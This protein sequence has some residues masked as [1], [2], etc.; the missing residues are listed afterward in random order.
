MHMPLPVPSSQL[1][2]RRLPASL[3]PPPSQLSQH[4]P[5][6]LPPFSCLPACLQA[7]QADP[8]FKTFREKLQAS[9]AQRA[10]LTLWLGSWR[11][12][13]SLPSCT[14]CRSTRHQ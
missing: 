3:L 4:P 9:T 13:N 8:K 2:C 10:Q 1:G 7:E 5:L 14:A 12:L 11:P 6:P